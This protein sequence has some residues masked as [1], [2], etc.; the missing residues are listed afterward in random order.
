MKC[1]DCGTNL[2]HSYNWRECDVKNHRYLCN[3]C[4]NERRHIYN[5]LHKKQHAKISLAWY[6]RNKSQSQSTTY[7]CRRKRNL[8]YPVN[9]RYAEYKYRA[10]HHN[11][12]FTLSLKEFEFL[13]LSP[14]IY[15]GNSINTYNGIDRVDNAKGYEKNN[16]VP[17]CMRCNRMKMDMS[18]EE[19]IAHLKNLQGVLL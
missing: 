2:F 18:L 16:C 13:I 14:C 5:K 8:K 3:D 12:K 9:T 1:I 17:C 10:K 7:R 15:C 19:F 4:D 6:Y 11:L